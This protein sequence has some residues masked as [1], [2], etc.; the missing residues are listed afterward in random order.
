ML[1]SDTAGEN[2]RLLAQADRL[3]LTAAV[4]VDG[5]LVVAGEGGVRRIELDQL[6]A[7]P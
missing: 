6:G 3:G 7:L 1:A 2:F 5:A 4:A